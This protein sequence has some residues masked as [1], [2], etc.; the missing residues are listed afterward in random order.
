[1]DWSPNGRWL[2]TADG[3]IHV[4]DLTNGVST[5]WLETRAE[6]K[7]ARFSPDGRSVAYASNAN[8]RFEVYVR[9]F[10]GAAQS[11]PVSTTGGDHPIWRDDGRELFFLSPGNELMSV[12]VTSSGNEISLG[13]PRKLFSI[14]LNDATREIFPPYDVAPGGERFLMNLPDRPGALFFL[15]GLDAIVAGR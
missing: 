9:A 1:S 3:D 6:E 13:Q 4:Y 2:L 11:I 15:Q 12:D 8:G 5:P 14:L 7:Q 10:E